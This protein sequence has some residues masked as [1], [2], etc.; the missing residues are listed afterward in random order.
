MNKNAVL[1]NYSIIWKGEDM[2]GK[3]TA[4]KRNIQE[5]IEEIFPKEKKL[6]RIP[7]DKNVQSKSII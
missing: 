2:I 7:I 3:T 6:I 1:K 5:I 4:I